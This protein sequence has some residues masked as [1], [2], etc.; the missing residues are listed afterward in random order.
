MESL[1]LKQH[2][3]VR[4]REAGIDDRKQAAQKC[5][6]DALENHPEL[7]SRLRSISRKD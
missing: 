5:L 2:R 6:L 1:D 4:K 7:H 3:E